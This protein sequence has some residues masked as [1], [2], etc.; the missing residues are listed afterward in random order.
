MPVSDGIQLSPPRRHS[1]FALL[2]RDATT[3]PV[4]RTLEVVI[5]DDSKLLRDALIFVLG[6][7]PEL[8]VVGEAANGVEAL[9]L[10]SRF[11][12]DVLL[13]DIR[14]P[15]LNGI[16]VL[17]RLARADRK[18]V[19]MMLT[20]LDTVGYRRRCAELGA[21][22]FFD[23]ANDIEEAVRVLKQMAAD[24]SLRKRPKVRNRRN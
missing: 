21:E 6:M 8:K 4:S 12:P 23:K 14:M 24:E 19:V 9:E 1:K 22:H 16:G 10:V 13:L 20:L 5:A 2:R 7:V 15:L 11:R 17:E 3:H 18:P